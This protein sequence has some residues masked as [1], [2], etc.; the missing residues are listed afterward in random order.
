MTGGGAKCLWVLAIGTLLS[1]APVYADDFDTVLG[2][3]L[4]AYESISDY[5]CLFMKTE[6]SKGQLGPREEIFLKFEKPFK[7]FMG[8]LN[9]HKKG[10]QVAYERGRHD[11]KLVIHQPG[12]LFG[13]AQVIFL[14]QNSPWVSEGSESYDI[15]DAGIGTFLTD[16][17]R[18]VAQAKKDGNLK[19]TTDGDVFETTFLNSTDD[20]DYFAYRIK[21]RFDPVNFMP[22]WM[23]L[24]GW[25]NQTTGIYE[26]NDLKL[27]V[28]A[29]DLELKKV[30]NKHLLKVYLSKPQ[31]SKPFTGNIVPSKQTAGSK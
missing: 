1:A 22:V 9:T 14:D 4:K 2:Q 5:R 11:G 12:L 6:E 30:A 19:V 24:I 18:A 21:V 17:A 26:Y 8:W 28:G 23:E 31:P 29:E 15:E 3:S 13:L 20:E 27:N 7:I 16:F 10:L 25:D